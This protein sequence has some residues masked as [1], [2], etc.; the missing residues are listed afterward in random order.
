VLRDGLI[1][2]GL[3]LLCLAAVGGVAFGAPGSAD[4]AGRA[5][6]ATVPARNGDPDPGRDEPPAAALDAQRQRDAWYRR[7][8]SALLTRRPPDEDAALGARPQ[9]AR[10]RFLPY[11][12]WRIERIHVLGRGAF[13]TI[14]DD[15]LLFAAEPQPGPATRMHPAERALSALAAPTREPILRNFLL[16][17]EGGSVVPTALADSER[18][19]RR[20]AYVR[21]ALIIL[22]PLP[23]PEQAVD[24]VVLVRDRWPWGVQASVRSADAQQ[25]AVFHRNVGGLGVNLEAELLHDRDRRPVDGWR[26]RASAVNVAGTFVDLALDTRSA[27][28]R[29]LTAWSAERRFSYPDI[30]LLGG[31][32]LVDETHKALPELPDGARL[33]SRVQDGWLGWNVHLRPAAHH[34]ERRLRLV[35]A[36]RVQD[37]A[38]AAPPLA[39]APGPRAWR[40]HRRYLGQLHLVGLDFYTTSLVHGYGETEDLPV[41]LWAAL[42]GGLETGDLPDRYYHG[43]RVIHPQLLQRGRYVTVDAALGGFRRGGRFEDGV[44]DVALST[45]SPLQRRAIGAWR[46]FVQVRYTLGVA[47]TDPLGL[48]LDTVGLR[49]LDTA[50]TAGSQRLVAELESVLF[51]RLAVAG[52]KLTA[53]GYGGSGLIARDREPLFDQRL[54][55]NLGVGLR[56]NNP[57]L[58]LPT[59]ELRLGALSGP[60][61]WEPALTVRMGEVKFAQRRL[62]GAQPGLLPYR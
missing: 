1:T 27:W 15:V 43:A 14:D 23:E 25:V 11:A 47:P 52:F 58:V 41:G 48:R 12:G 24:V 2:G 39:F 38:Y 61:G 62:P 56:L 10:E 44:V 29:D 34:D 40:D 28:D 30:R 50:D 55:A 18:L 19:L 17:H 54:H 57:G 36:L 49:D 35:P 3:C 4:S 51:T 16:F 53:F 46:H 22:L 6:G 9:L 45:F 5:S 21:D 7:G 8:F 31:W 20:Q 13:G 60:Q 26:T 37:V 33:Q 59:I 32:S 42:V